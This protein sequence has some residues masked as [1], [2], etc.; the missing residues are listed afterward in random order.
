MDPNRDSALLGNQSR[1]VLRFLVRLAILAALVATA[2]AGF[3]SA[4][5]GLLVAA[6][7]FCAVWAAILRE[8]LFAPILTHWD[9]AANSSCLGSLLSDSSD[10]SLLLIRLL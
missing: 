9:E 4:I 5:P 6:G 7:I 10:T 3:R 2:H 1:A 8:Q